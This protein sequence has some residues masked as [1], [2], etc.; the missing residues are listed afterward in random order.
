MTVS[1]GNRMDSD[2]GIE[3]LAEAVMPIERVPEEYRLA[4]GAEQ[5]NA[6]HS[7]TTD[8]ASFESDLSGES[9]PTPE[10]TS[11]SL[12][13]SH[14]HSETLSLSPE[15]KNPLHNHRPGNLIAEGH[16]SVYRLN[17]PQHASLRK[18]DVIEHLSPLRFDE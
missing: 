7:L 6:T 4:A 1:S 5:E 9:F 14:R 17:G 8:Y 11:V 15:H 18:G 2:E 13:A 10:K 3:R 12:Q 16:V